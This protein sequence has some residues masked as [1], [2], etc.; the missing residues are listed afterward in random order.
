M[1]DYEKIKEFLKKEGWEINKQ[2]DPNS[3]ARTSDV[4]THKHVIYTESFLRTIPFNVFLQSYEL[5]FYENLKNSNDFIIEKVLAER[6]RQDLKFGFDRD[7]NPH[8]WNT[9]LGEE[10]GEVSR[11]ILE[12]DNQNY[13]EELIQTMAVCMAMLEAFY[14]QK[15][16]MYPH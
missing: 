12:E 14:R 13:E 6:K 8:V 16:N 9:I 11:A 10:V 1:N 15:S 3:N 5:M 4:F 2:N 7:L